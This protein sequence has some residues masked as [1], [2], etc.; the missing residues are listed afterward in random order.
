MVRTL[1]RLWIALGWIANDAK[2]WLVRHNLDALDQ[3]RI[4]QDLRMLAHQIDHPLQRARTLVLIQ[5]KLEVHAHH[6][7]VIARGTQ[8]QRERTVARSLLKL[9]EHA[10]WIPE[11]VLRSNESAHRTHHAEHRNFSTDRRARALGI[12]ELLASANGA[13]RNVMR[14]HH[15]DGTLNLFRRRA[16]HRT[17]RGRTGNRAVHHMVNLVG[18]ETEHLRKAP[19][20]LIR[21]HH[22]AQRRRTIKA[23]H[24]R[25]SNRH[26][27]EIIVPKLASNEAEFLAESKVRAVGIPFAHRAAIC[28]DRLLRRNLHG[29][30]KE[31]NA[32]RV[33]VLQRL[34]AQDHRRVGAQS[35]RANAAQHAV[36]MKELGALLH[37]LRRR[38]TPH[39]FAGVLTEFER[40]IA[41]GLQF[42]GHGNL[43]KSG[44]GVTSS[45]R[46]DRSAASATV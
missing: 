46:A 18:L 20:N 35:H 9:P 28:N 2:R 6:C 4:L 43:L 37:R 31:R 8:H 36:R 3:P 11:D 5:P 21:K 12:T 15:A 19:A 27:I 1:P 14:N 40:L 24:L 34:F 13:P 44:S 25:R 29:A 45:T 33:G 22:A 41:V 38:S 39:E 17:P 26:W 30:S 7:K 10:L 16:H 32:V 42:N 23:L